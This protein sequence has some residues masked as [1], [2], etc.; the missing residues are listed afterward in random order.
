[1]KKFIVSL[2]LLAALIHLG[3]KEIKLRE[4]S[5]TPSKNGK[6]LLTREGAADAR[7]YFLGSAAVGLLALAMLSRMPVSA[8]MFCI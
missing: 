1:M 5:F 3:A 4:F 7:G 6:F 8:T 2:L